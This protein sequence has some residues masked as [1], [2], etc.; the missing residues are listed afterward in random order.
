[1]RDKFCNRVLC[2]CRCP[3]NSEYSREYGCVS[4]FDALIDA[5]SGGRCEAEMRRLL[6]RGNGELPKAPARI[7]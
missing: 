1:M 3:G 6:Y 4:G 2:G 5:T 7:R